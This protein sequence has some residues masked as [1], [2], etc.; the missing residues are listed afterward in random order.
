VAELQNALEA[1][2]VVDDGEVFDGFGIDAEE[3]RLDGHGEKVPADALSKLVGIN[4]LEPP[5]EPQPQPQP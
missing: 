2:G 4:V 3:V 1:A 5:P